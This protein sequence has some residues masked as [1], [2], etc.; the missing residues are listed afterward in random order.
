MEKVFKKPNFFLILLT[1]H[2]DFAEFVLS[3]WKSF[4]ETVRRPEK[5]FS[6]LEFD[7]D[8]DEIIKI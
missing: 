8:Y 7:P 6:R 5:M 1:L 3:G 2:S 4:C